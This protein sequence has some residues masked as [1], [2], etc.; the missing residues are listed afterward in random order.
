MSTV[1]SP[2]STP[3]ALLC[4][5]CGSVVREDQAWCLECG[6]AAR[7]RVHPSPHWRLPLLAT[8][9]A[10]LA[11]AAGIALALVLL[12][13]NPE[14]TPAAVTVTVPATTPQATVPTTPTTPSVTVPT[15]TTPTVV[16]TPT[17]PTPPPTTSPSGGAGAP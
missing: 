3:G 11:L 16:T 9:L 15:T 10:L 5:R 6:F 13:D 2:P 1:P 4:P 12:L 14:S 8:A 7:T 17:V